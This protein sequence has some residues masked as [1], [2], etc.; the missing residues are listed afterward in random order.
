MHSAVPTGPPSVPA[1]SDRRRRRG[2]PLAVT[3]VSEAVPRPTLRGRFFRRWL[4]IGLVLVALAVALAV[5]AAFLFD[6]AYEGRVL[7]GVSV[8][9][10]DASG[11][12][13]AQLRDQIAALQLLPTTVNVDLDGQQLSAS[14]DELGG[15]LD[16][17][18]A[19]SAALAA[20]RVSGPL[21]DVPERIGLWRDGL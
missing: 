9:G 21:A 2:D 11:L 10:I 17:D 6:R 16:V 19:V 1:T 14:A 3:S 20:G 5:G 8:A 7:P 4:P 15:H 18:A 13:Q 12:S